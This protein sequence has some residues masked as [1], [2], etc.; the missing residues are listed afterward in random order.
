M[1]K[2]FCVFCSLV[3][4][5]TQLFA[6]GLLAYPRKIN[7]LKTQYFD[8]LY[9]TE[10]TSV[11]MYL[12]EN[13][14]NF[15]AKAQYEL[16]T[17]N[18]F[19][20]PVVI[21]PDSDELSVSYSS[22]PYN[23]LVIYDGVPT[24]GQ[25]ISDDYLG[26]MLYREIFLAVAQSKMSPFNQFIHD[27]VGGE[28]FT[29]VSLINLPS[30]IVDGYGYLVESNYDYTRINDGYFL[31]LL[32]QAKLEGKFPSWF[33]TFAKRDVHPGK[34]L[35]QAAGT[36]FSAYLIQSR[37][38]EKYIE[39]WEE[40]GNLHPFFAA[41]II[42]KVYNMKI[43]DLWKEFEDSVPLPETL[44]S[45]FLVGQEVKKLFEES[46][47]LYNHLV[48]SDYGL[49]WYDNFR[50]EIDVYD[51]SK[52][53]KL[54]TAS[55]IQHLSIS[56]D[57][58]YLVV[59][60]VQSK[61]QNSL[62]TNLT[63]I[64]DL[65]TKQF[66]EDSFKLRE[67]SII[68]LEDGHYALAGVNVEEKTAK[69]QIYTLRNFG[70]EKNEL[71]YEEAFPSEVIP[72]SPAYAGVGKVMFIQSYAEKNLLTVL[73]VASRDRKEFLV[74]DL[75][76]KPIKIKNLVY[77]NIGNQKNEQESYTFQ[78]TVLNE[79]S[80]VRTGSFVLDEGIPTAV[81]LQGI[82]LSGGVNNPVILNNKV[83]FAAKKFG[84]DELVYLSYENLAF[85]PGQIV[86]T[87][88]EYIQNEKEYTVEEYDISN[89]SLFT[90]WH[91]FSIVPLIPIKEISFENGADSAFG[92]GTIIKL[93]PDPFMNNKLTFSAAWSY[94]NLDFVWMFN[95]PE[96]EKKLINQTSQTVSKDKTFAFFYEN[97]STPLVI[98]AGSLF[99][100]NLYGEYEF[101]AL[102]GA[103][104]DFPLGFTFNKLD[105]SIF[106]EYIASTDYYDANLSDIYCSKND[107]PAF[108]DAYETLKLST[109]VDFNNI[110][111]YGNSCFQQKGFSAG[112]NV[113]SLWDIFKYR[114]AEEESE[115][116]VSQVF[117]GLHG[118]IAIPKIIPLKQNKNGWIL[119]LPTKTTLEIS[120]KAGVFLNANVE[121]LLI[122]KEIQNGIPYV[123]FYVNRLGLTAG[124]DFSLR[125]DT[126]NIKLPDFRRFDYM[127][128]I[129]TNSEPNHGI[130]LLMNMD[131]LFPIG[132]L[133]ERIISSKFKTTF[134]PNTGGYTFNLDFTV[135]F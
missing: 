115:P 24:E 108:N 127:Y 8:I 110:H 4:A 96:E 61:K 97:T 16:E 64:Y 72:V 32:S 54:F 17:D 44:D 123:N 104:W 129:F 118:S 102:T 12:A 59:S 89:Y 13:A 103:S 93:V 86:E 66:F 55:G 109:I 45:L 29:P 38:I 68:V 2:R 116:Y 85:E 46:E 79:N 28:K 112:F 43:S 9:S 14:D 107:F 5:L 133:S 58:K 26:S 20:M 51:F 65:Q 40:C 81:S 60:F 95:P 71:I 74:S 75:E 15:F 125:Y 114:H 122:G 105:F 67:A 35:N 10:S 30:S 78:Y 121:T 128:E 132:P 76:E 126:S 90:Y 101:Q 70:S 62:E 111:D 120:S 130:Y 98:K 63:W 80:F 1:K 135:H 37:G 117:L 87:H 94:V 69:F 47:S 11:A 19:R 39:L 99:R 22:Y 119:S 57:S 50:N 33:Q 53:K 36:G 48:Y 42:R 7:L 6:A 49:I 84:Y 31:R 23:R 91:R 88:S 113:Y 41:G 92:L 25:Q 124:Y 52:E 131:F 18:E 56:P 100:C 34:Q 82:D 83:I 27:T 3:F 77:Q 134:F 106:G 73:D 21:S